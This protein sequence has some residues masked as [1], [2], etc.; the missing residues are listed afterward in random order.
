M[1]GSHF[2][3]FLYLQERMG[4]ELVEEVHDGVGVQRSRTDHNVALR[5][6]SMRRISAALKI[7]QSLIM[8]CSA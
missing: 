8:D 6:G 3:F 1:G 7:D 2:S 4:V 5:L